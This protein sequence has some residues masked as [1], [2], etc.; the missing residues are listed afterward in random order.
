MHN[1]P[2]LVATYLMPIS[3]GW[4]TNEEFLQYILFE[5]VENVTIVLVE[6]LA[7]F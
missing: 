4:N 1:R 5:F 2:T 3:C 7:N 6:G